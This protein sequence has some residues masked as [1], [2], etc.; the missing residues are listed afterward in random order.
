MVLDWLESGKWKVRF[1]VW[2]V[3]QACFRGG[4]AK[5]RRC[6]VGSLL[7]G[8]RTCEV[9]ATLQW[10]QVVRKYGFLWI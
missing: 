10:G 1:R 9:T 4:V 7:R 5:K 2:G 8:G 3:F 6:F